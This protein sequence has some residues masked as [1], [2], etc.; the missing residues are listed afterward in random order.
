MGNPSSAIHLTGLSHRWNRFACNINE[1]LIRDTATQMKTLGFLTAGYNY[2]NID[3]CWN[4]KSRDASG[5][6][7]VDSTKFPSVFHAQ[8]II[9]LPGTYFIL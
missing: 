3:D 9:V 8:P 7:V 2:I 5:Q 6:L 4:T 1:A